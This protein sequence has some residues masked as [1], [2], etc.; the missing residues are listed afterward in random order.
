MFR[1]RH[2]VRPAG[3]GADEHERAHQL[4]PRERQRQRDVSAHR[5]RDDVRGPAVEDGRGVV[6]EVAES[7]T[8]RR[9][10]ASGR[11]RACRT[12]SSG[13]AAQR[14]A[15]AP[16][17][18]TCSGRALRRAAAARRRH[19]PRRRA[20]RLRNYRRALPRRQGCDRHRRRPRHRPRARARARARRARRSSSTTSAATLA[21]EGGRRDAGAAGRRRDRGDGRRGGRQR[22]RRRRLGRARERLVRQAVDTFGGLDVL[23]NNAGI[24]RDRMLVNMTEDEWDAVIEVHL[25]G[26]FAPTRHAAAYWRERVEGRRGGARAR[27][28]HLQPVGCLRQRRPDELRRR[29][30]RHRGVHAH[31][32]AGARAL[33]RHRQLPSRRTRAPA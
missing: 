23:V 29:E 5:Q 31:R 16:A 1:A 8:D 27:D 33:R 11:F 28:Q 4:G 30:G 9:A 20:A 6:G 7:S 25:K 15:P 13:T 26:H 12:R 10:P 21:G 18:P 2:A 19:A 24:L 32:R 3:A 14:R 17:T 22:R